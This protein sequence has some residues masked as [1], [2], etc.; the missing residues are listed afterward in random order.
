MANHTRAML[1]NLP[2]LA[3]DAPAL[4]RDALPED[5]VTLFLDWLGVAVRQGVPEPHAMTL[6]TV[7]AEGIPDARALLLKD[8]DVRGWAFASE[9]SSPKGRQLRDRPAAALSF[10]WQPLV[11]AV[12]VRGAVIEASREESE[13]DLRERGEEARRRVDADDWTLWRVRP[14]R[15]EF[16]QGSSDRAHHRIEYLA[17]GD[18]WRIRA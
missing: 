6:S 8:V 2:S 9:A 18:G 12:R 11:R 16:W 7:D 5:P 4:D 15:V 1:R 13:A 10:W 3:G 14:T 17:D